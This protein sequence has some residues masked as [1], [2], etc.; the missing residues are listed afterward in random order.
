MRTRNLSCIFVSG[1]RRWGGSRRFS[2]T[3]IA[4]LSLVLSPIAALGQAQKGSDDTPQTAK[5]SIAPNAPVNIESRKPTDAAPKAESRS[6][7]IR[8]EK[9]L[10]LINVTVTDPLNRFVTGLEKQHFRLF[11]DKVEQNIS[12]FSSEDAPISIGLVFDTSGSMGPKLQKSRQAAAEFFKTANPADEFF[13][14]Q[15]ND[16]PELSVPFTTDTDKVQSTLTFTQSKG[17]TALL[18]SVYLA[19]HEMKKAHNPRKALLIIS[20]GGDNSS[21]YTETEIKNAVREADVQIFAIGIFESLSNRGRT[22]EE[23]SGPGLL[24]EL[25]EQT[26]GRE[27]AVENIAELPDIAAK[28]GIEL[29]NEYILGY[30]PKNQERDGKYRRVQ[31]KLNQPRG[32]PPLKAYFR[33]GY[34]AP[35][36]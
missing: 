24:N 23:A 7:D 31:V 33:L 29:R 6:H 10:V 17:R 2:I 32:L 30:T 14:V 35:A 34:Y 18:D 4:L 15:F 25:A 8:V 13:L 27:Y 26:G 9:Q 36:N 19:M 11:E 5:S 28:I 16:R 20:D 3:G 12:N 1:V 21:R 22:P